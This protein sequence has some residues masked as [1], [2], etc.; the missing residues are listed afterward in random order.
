MKIF[1]LEYI[2]AEEDST[3]YHAVSHAALIRKMVADV[4]ASLLHPRLEI[5]ML[6]VDGVYTPNHVDYSV[7][8]SEVF[9]DMFGDAARMA[10]LASAQREIDSFKLF[11]ELAEKED[12]AC[13]K[14]HPAYNYYDVVEI[15]VAE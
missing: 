8:F 2:G 1:A 11:M 14:A 9:K 13:V 5:D 7:G 10:D 4:Q 3:M 15:E 12:I 6:S